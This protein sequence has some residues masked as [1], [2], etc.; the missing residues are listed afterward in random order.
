MDASIIGIVAILAIPL[1]GIL[2]AIYLV[3]RLGR[4][5]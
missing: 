1:A 2:A 5:Q 3:S 4:G